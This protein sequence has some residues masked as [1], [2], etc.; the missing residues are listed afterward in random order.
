M[1]VK[2]EEIIGWLEKVDVIEEGYSQ[3]T[4]DWIEGETANGDFSPVNSGVSE[5]DLLESLRY[6]VDNVLQIMRIELPDMKL[7]LTLKEMMRE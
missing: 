7:F 4:I 5:E 6:E 3:F 2:Y 1:S